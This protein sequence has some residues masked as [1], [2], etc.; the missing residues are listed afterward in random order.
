MKESNEKLG[1]GWQKGPHFPG[2]VWGPP[3]MENGHVK[4]IIKNHLKKIRVSGDCVARC[5]MVMG[6]NVV[7]SKCCRVCML[8]CRNGVVSEWCCVG[9][10]ICLV[11]FCRV[12]FFTVTKS[13]TIVSPPPT[14][15]VSCVTCHLSHVICH[16]SHF[17]Y[18]Y[19]YEWEQPGCKEAL[20]G[21]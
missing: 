21:S 10:A 14:C 19:I 8:L 11:T 7:E 5:G 12:T 4:Q 15:F 18:I 20:S 9:M 13:L 6:L 2:K 1:V 17:M 3:L 16:M